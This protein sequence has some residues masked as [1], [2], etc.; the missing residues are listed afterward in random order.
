MNLSY[1]WCHDVAWV[2]TM[3][4]EVEDIRPDAPLHAR[5]RQGTDK[6]RFPHV[7]HWHP[8]LNNHFSSGWFA[9]EVARKLGYGPVILCGVP[10]VGSESI[11]HDYLISVGKLPETASRT[12]W[13]DHYAIRL[14]TAMAGKY[15]PMDPPA[16]IYSMSGFTRKFIGAPPRI[17]GEDHGG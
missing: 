7:D 3:H 16:G 12:T 14:E 8:E 5:V 10:L 2:A 6:A 15:P 4:P 13:F 11:D 9:A 17:A 1:L